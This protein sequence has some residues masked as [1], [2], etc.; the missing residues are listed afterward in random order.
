MCVC[1]DF[2]CE[3]RAVYSCQVMQVLTYFLIDH[4]RYNV[5]VQVSVNC[6]IRCSHGHYWKECSLLGCDAM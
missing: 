4:N 1:Q 2:A 3:L 6:E 5:L